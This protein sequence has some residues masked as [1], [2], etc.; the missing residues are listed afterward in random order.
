MLY[1]RNPFDVVCRCKTARHVCCIISCLCDVI[2]HL[3]EAAFFG[4]YSIYLINSV[5]PRRHC[6]RFASALLSFQFLCSESQLLGMASQ[7]FESTLV[8]SGSAQS[9]GCTCLADL[10][11]RAKQRSQNVDRAK[12]E[13]CPLL[14]QQIWLGFRLSSGGGCPSG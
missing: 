9:V 13:G 14:D 1:A 4:R 12:T 10:T 8:R 3:I 7:R 2:T 6:I 5:K 11:A